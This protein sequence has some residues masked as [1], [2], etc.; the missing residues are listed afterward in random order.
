MVIA[1]TAGGCS[2]GGDEPMNIDTAREVVAAAAAD[3]F[4]I[5]ADQVDVSPAQPIGSGQCYL[6]AAR[7]PE[8]LDPHRRHYAVLADG[9]LVAGQQTPEPA[10]VVLDACTEGEGA[11]PLP[12]D[13]LARLII[14][15]EQTPGPLALLESPWAR[16]K[17][18]ELGVDDMPP[19]V[20]VNG[21]IATYTFLAE[22]LEVDAITR[23]TALRA[24][25][26]P[27]VITYDDL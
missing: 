15:L 5:P 27:L 9:T 1:A 3:D 11:E 21:S 17:L 2:S 7:D 10:T 6:V 14:G 26:Q 24:V 23:V 18:A 4:D 8:S 22:D 19:S 16:R 13:E 25:G 20:E 12:A